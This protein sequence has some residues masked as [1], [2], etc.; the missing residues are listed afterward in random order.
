MIAEKRI[1]ATGSELAAGLAADV[2]GWLRA[3]IAKKDYAI[4]AVSGGSTPKPFFAALSNQLLDWSKV[5]IT[6]VDERQVPEDNA[7]S[8]AK[9]VKETLL[10]NYAV[11]AQFI[12]LFENPNAK[13]LKSFDVV[14]LGMGSD[15]HTASFFPRGDNLEQALDLASH[16]AIIEINAPGAGEP[17]LTFTLPRLLATTQLVLHIQGADKQAVLEKALSG[18]DDFEMPVRAVLNS[19]KPLTVYWCP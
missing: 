10:Q 1:F 11:Q 12:P 3:A 6:L 9:L 13:N 4:L 18:T 16:H 5:Q 8:N 2:A 17:R 15:G 19:P 14:I 7:R